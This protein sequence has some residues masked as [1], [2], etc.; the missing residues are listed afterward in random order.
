[1]FG[2]RA[3]ILKRHGLPDR[4]AFEIE[5]CQVHTS[6]WRVKFSSEGDVPNALDIG[7]A[8]RLATALRSVDADLAAQ[9]DKNVALAVGYSKGKA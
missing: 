1:M 2:D 9:I 7:G 4:H 3:E 5:P 6:E 8:T